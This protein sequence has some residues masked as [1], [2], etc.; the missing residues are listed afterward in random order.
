[1]KGYRL[2]KVNK[3]VR[4]GLCLVATGILVGC[5][6][7]LSGDST[8]APVK[9]SVADGVAV[10]QIGDEII[11]STMLMG[12]AKAAKK[13]EQ[14]KSLAGRLDF[15]SHMIETKI[16]AQE[17]RARGYEKRPRIVRLKAV[18]GASAATDDARVDL[19]RRVDNALAQELTVEEMLRHSRLEQ[20]SFKE[21]RAYFDANQDQF[22]KGPQLGLASA[23]I[24]NGKNSEEAKTLLETLHASLSSAPTQDRL[25]MFQAAASQLAGRGVRYLENLNSD[26]ELERWGAQVKIEAKKLSA[27]GMLSPVFQDGN[28]WILFLRMGQRAKISIPYESVELKLREQLLQDKRQAA[29]GKFLA[30][31]KKK[32]QVQ[33]FHKA[34]EQMN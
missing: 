4:I 6:V 8:R 23:R 11:S 9:E 31:L 24:A 33:I 13:L 18:D 20:V 26:A 17:A 34:L 27:N 7:S 32:T 15:L 10:A 28:N 14:T 2:D 25:K 3:R 16:L 12:S 21:V 29:F 30:N 1:M 19:A 22:N 5:P